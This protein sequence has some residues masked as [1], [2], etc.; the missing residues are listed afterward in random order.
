MSPAFVDNDGSLNWRKIGYHAR[1]AF[2]VLLSLAVLVGG[3]WFVYD[4]ARDAWVEWRTAD[5]YIG[6]GVDDVQVVIPMGASVTRIGDIL[7]ENEVIK[8]TKTFRDEAADNPDS[9]LIQA[10][11]Y[12][13]KTQI[14]AAMAL[15]MLLDTD[16]LE[17]TMV[18]IPEGMTLSQQWTILERNLGLQ[19]AEISDAINNTE[20]NLPDWRGGQVEGYMFPDTYQVAEPVNPSQIVQAQANRFTQIADNLDLEARAA[21]LGY[22][23]HE[24]I[25]IAS[26]IDREVGTA[27]YR[28]MVSAVIYNRLAQGMPLQMDSSVHYAI[29]DYSKVTTTAEDR[30]IDSPYNT[31]R[32][33]GLPPGAIGN[34]GAAAIEAALAPAETDAL[35]FV[36]V[37]LDTGETL[38]A[39]TNEEHEQNRL[40]FQQWCQANTGRC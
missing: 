13:L 6:E 20:L 27:E 18:T 15:E 17:V 29:G 36:T 30:Q 39:A 5:D 12:N 9:S 22:T 19:R 11:R 7:V 26:I 23:P 16:N 35:F 34:P 31:Y 24:I 38:F 2:A 4:T 28:D 40:L 32:Y 10:G 8:S 37:N 25:T 3:G 1:S 33:P 14:P 21:E